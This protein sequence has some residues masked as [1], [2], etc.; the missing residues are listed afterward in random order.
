MRIAI[1]SFDQVPAEFTDDRRLTAAIEA[2]GAATEVRSWSDPGV[3]WNSYD[4]VV[5]R[6]TWDYSTRRDEFVAWAEGVGPRLQN[7]AAIIRWNSDKRYV[8]DLGEAGI[9]VV[10]TRYVEPGDDPPVIDREVVVKPTVSVGARDTGRFA[11]A[12]ADQALALVAA[13]N[14]GGRTAMVQP[15]NPTVDTVGETAVVMLDGRF[16]HALRKRAVLRAGEVAP[17]RDDAVGA[18]EVMYDPDLVG[19]GEASPAE[20]E[21]AA[22]V[23]AELERRFGEIP[24]YARVDL[25]A[26]EDG[27]PVLLELEAIEPNLYHGQVPGS[28]ERFAEAIVARAHA[29]ALA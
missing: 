19:P 11:P 1:A 10:E 3:D 24:L 12:D 14:A 15:F 18:A 8:A 7:S 13:I 5:V 9:P 23:V 20:L 27:E 16:S 25:L 17:V 26:G 6:T 22:A 28:A 4:L 29:S 2:A 21:A